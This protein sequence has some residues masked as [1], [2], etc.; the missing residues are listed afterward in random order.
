MVENRVDNLLSKN[1]VGIKV[2]RSLWG[3]D[4]MVVFVRKLENVL[5]AIAVNRTLLCQSLCYQ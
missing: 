1:S 5:L 3:E 2:D 4:K